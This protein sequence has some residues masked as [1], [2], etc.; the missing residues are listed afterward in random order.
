M[1]ESAVQLDNKILESSVN[2][3]WKQ[4]KKLACHAVAFFVQD[5]KGMH[6]KELFSA[7]FPHVEHITKGLRTRLLPPLLLLRS[8]L[9]PVLLLRLLKGQ[10]LGR[11]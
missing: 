8:Y 1:Y 4:M 6:A 11:L 10:L 3:R 9:L 7:L 2:T 5:L